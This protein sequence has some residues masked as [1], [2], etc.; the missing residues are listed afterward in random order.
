MFPLTCALF[1]YFKKSFLERHRRWWTRTSLPSSFLRTSILA[2]THRREHFMGVG[3]P[4]E[5]WHIMGAPPKKSK[6]KHVE[7]VG[8]FT[9]PVSPLTLGGP[10]WCQV[11]P[12]A[13]D[14][15]HKGKW[16][17][18]IE[19]WLPQL[20]RTLPK[21]VTSSSPNNNGVILCGYCHAHSG[22]S[23]SSLMSF[24]S[25]IIFNKGLHIF[26]LIYFSMCYFYIAKYLFFILSSTDTFRS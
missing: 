5:F 3:N 13:C 14:F 17:F 9:L 4:T 21:R 16:V 18:V 26:Y 19:L 25:L 7:E 6:H 11:R 20:Y 15:S 23:R 1:S 2:V 22:H 12:L 8:S 10:A 24:S